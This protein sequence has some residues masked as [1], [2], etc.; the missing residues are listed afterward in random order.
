MGRTIDEL[1]DTTYQ[2][3]DLSTGSIQE[4]WLTCGKEGCTCAQ[5]DKHGPYYYFVYT[6]TD[7]NTRQISLDPDE[8]DELEER[9]ANYEELQDALHE[10][11]EREAERR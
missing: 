11:A 7:R 1:R 10:L 5:G 8:V 4:R 9:I 3:G 6:D 2:L